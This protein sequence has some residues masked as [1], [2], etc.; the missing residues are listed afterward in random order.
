MVA[1]CSGIHPMLNQAY[2]QNGDDVVI[3]RPVGV[4]TDC[5]L[6]QFVPTSAVTLKKYVPAARLAL[7]HGLVVT[8]AA[9]DVYVPPNPW[10]TCRW[11][12]T[13]RAPPRS[14]PP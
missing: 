5:T 8:A 12:T 10:S 14:T 6:T 1:F 3:T 11:C 7:V 9:S 13:R 4:A 2:A